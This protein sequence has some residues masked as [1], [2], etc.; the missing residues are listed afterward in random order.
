MKRKG[1]D[2]TLIDHIAVV[3]FDELEPFI[4]GCV[5]LD[6]QVR[7]TEKSGAL[8]LVVGP[9]SRVVAQIDKHFCLRTNSVFDGPHFL[10]F[11]SSLIATTLNRLSSSF[12]LFSWTSS[13]TQSSR[14]FQLQRGSIP[15]VILDDIETK[16]LKNQLDEASQS[17]SVVRLSLEY[18]DL[19]P[20]YTLRLQVFR[21]TVLNI[22]LIILLFMLILFITGLVFIKIRWRPNSHRDIWLRTLARSAVNK[23]EIRKFEKPTPQNLSSINEARKGRG[24]LCLTSKRKYLPVFGSLTSVAHSCASQERCSICLDEYKEGQELRVLFCGHEFHPKCVDPWLLSNRRCPLCQ[25]DIVYKEY[26]KADPTPKNNRASSLPTAECSNQQ[27]EL[28]LL[29]P[30]SRPSADQTVPS[31]N[32]HLHIA[33]DL[34]SSLERN[35]RYRPKRVDEQQFALPY[36]LP[37]NTTPQV[38]HSIN[39]DTRRRY[40]R[41]E[42]AFTSRISRK[43]AQ[44]RTRS[45]G[46]QQRRR[47]LRSKRSSPNDHRLSAL[48]R[49]QQLPQIAD[50]ISGLEH[51]QLCEEMFALLAKLFKLVEYCSL[52][53]IA[54]DYRYSSD[55]S[56]Y[57]EFETDVAAIAT[58]ET[59]QE[60]AF[61][62]FSLTASSESSPSTSMRMTRFRVN[63]SQQQQR[64]SLFPLV[65]TAPLD[66]ISF[67]ES[68]G[69]IC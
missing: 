34:K 2:R 19:R 23:M 31:A 47:Q 11:C 1:Y 68:H 46:A 29:S 54:Y 26:P 38:S 39:R 41:D 10:K 37:S 18:V 36:L 12:I 57:P 64:I 62:Y 66:R 28:P 58:A 27:Q 3:F 32:S 51:F 55:I 5:S 35:Q 6:N 8:G 20:Q 52:Q 33:N 40:G 25:Y 4:T 17:G 43:C 67:E 16:R 42:G 63:N 7:F 21:P 9:E 56:S 65:N 44:H 50:T 24:L 14:V 13:V 53:S 49:E 69:D 48:P 59:Q 60:A 22:G 45:L 61:P 30:A 15:V